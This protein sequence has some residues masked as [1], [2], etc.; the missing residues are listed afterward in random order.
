ME[1]A[2]LGGMLHS[3]GEVVITNLRH[4]QALQEAKESL[5]LVQKA[6]GEGVEEDFYTID[7]MNAYQSFGKIIGES[8]EEDLVEEIF[9]K[10]CMGK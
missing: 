6:I 4:V 3:A 5:L 10:F 7:L 1:S 9:S 8:V 2:F